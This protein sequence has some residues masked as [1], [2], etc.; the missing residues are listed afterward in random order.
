MPYKPG[1]NLETLKLTHTTEERDK[2]RKE[3][4]LQTKLK[5]KIL[6]SLKGNARV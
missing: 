3:T 1:R 2:K 6:S 4:I 5:E